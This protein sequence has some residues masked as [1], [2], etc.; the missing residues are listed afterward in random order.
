LET[1]N[2]CQNHAQGGVNLRGYIKYQILFKEQAEVGER[3]SLTST[4]SEDKVTLTADGWQVAGDSSLSFEECVSFP[5]RQ[6]GF[7]GWRKII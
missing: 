1:S 7:S 6:L 5:S 4:G 2:G 3:S